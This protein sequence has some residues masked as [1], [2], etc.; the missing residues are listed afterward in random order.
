M[1]QIIGN[2]KYITQVNSPEK[3]MAFTPNGVEYSKL[4]ADCV[5]NQT[6]HRISSIYHD[7]IST[8]ITSVHTKPIITSTS[9]YQ[10]AIAMDALTLGSYLSGEGDGKVFYKT[11]ITNSFGTINISPST[12]AHRTKILTTIDGSD[13]ELVLN[14]NL[15]IDL[16]H[17]TGILSSVPSFMTRVIVTQKITIKKGVTLTIKVRGSILLEFLHLITEDESN[18]IVHE[19][20]NNGR[21][22]MFVYHDVLSND[23][24]GIEQLIQY[25]PDEASSVTYYGKFNASNRINDDSNLPHSE[26]AAL[27]AIY[28]NPGIRVGSGQFINYRPLNNY[29]FTCLDM[30]KRC[31]IVTSCKGI[32]SPS[33]PNESN[34][35]TS[36]SDPKMATVNGTI[37]IVYSNALKSWLDSQPS[38]SN[39]F[40]FPF[41]LGMLNVWESSSAQNAKKYLDGF[42]DLIDDYMTIYSTRKICKLPMTFAPS[43]IAIAPVCVHKW[44]RFTN[45]L[46]NTGVFDRYSKFYTSYIEAN[47]NTNRDDNDL[48]YNTPT[49]SSM[50]MFPI[51]P[52][53]RVSSASLNNHLYWV[54]PASL[55]GLTQS[56][57]GKFI[58]TISA[59]AESSREY[60][61]LL[62]DSTGNLYIRENDALLFCSSDTLLFNITYPLSGIY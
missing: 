42:I 59:F 54:K 38:G 21:L 16:S 34:A 46:E 4:E 2:K 29:D 52:V 20:W 53:Y 51:T 36:P 27:E 40:V 55:P 11:H 43:K 13:D 5:I 57:S 15:T 49:I 33:I 19:Y 41:T 14:N 3:Y 7:K 35:Q 32:V 23:S 45:D 39:R 18:L 24:K 47:Y 1:I 62:I 17:D 6:N 10:N 48:V 60:T 26:W 37:K 58:P 25:S 28:N 8:S 30:K 12:I 44:T 50:L 9:S 22:G 56:Y 61:T 31:Y